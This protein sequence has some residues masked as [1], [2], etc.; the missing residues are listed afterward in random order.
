M[1]RQ[2]TITDLP[3]YMKAKNAERR[4]NAKRAGLCCHCVID[5]ARPNRT[6][7]QSC[8]DAGSIRR[9]AA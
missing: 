6:T 2:K 1:S 3:A 8:A 7:C 5:Q 4:E 9:K